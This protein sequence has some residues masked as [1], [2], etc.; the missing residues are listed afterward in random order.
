[1]TSKFW[2]DGSG[3]T[4]RHLKDLRND[5]FANGDNNRGRAWTTANLGANDACLVVGLDRSEIAGDIGQTWSLSPAT[6]GDQVVVLG[7]KSQ[8][9]VGTGLVEVVVT[10]SSHPMIGPNGVRPRSLVEQFRQQQLAWTDLRDFLNDWH[11]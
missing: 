6:P 11:N 3:T 7:H 2:R 4:W 5:V 9:T 10:V 1:V 8:K